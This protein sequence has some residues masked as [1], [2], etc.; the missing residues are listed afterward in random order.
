MSVLNKLKN[1]FHYVRFDSFHV[2]RAIVL[3]VVIVVALVVVIMVV[4]R[5]KGGR[6]D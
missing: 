3:L 4:D 2:G 6:I 5:I 1:V